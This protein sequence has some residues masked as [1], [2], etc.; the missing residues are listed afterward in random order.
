M[1]IWATQS[2]E[3]SM[4]CDP[5]E[6][7]I[8]LQC[9]VTPCGMWLHQKPCLAV[10]HSLERFN[11]MVSLVRKSVEI[12]VTCESPHEDRV[13]TKNHCLA[14]QKNLVQQ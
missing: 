8:A 14:V 10:Y 7:V 9:L 12:G 11:S 4:T 1:G 13:C 3:F 5:T 6:W 2:R